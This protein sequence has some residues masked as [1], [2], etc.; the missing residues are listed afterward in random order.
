MVDGSGSTQMCAE[1]GDAAYVMI[2]NKDTVR[3]AS[4]RIEELLK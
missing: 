3:T 1:L 4:E 2:P